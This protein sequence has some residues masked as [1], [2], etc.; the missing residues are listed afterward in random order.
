MR[1]STTDLFAPAAR[2]AAAG[3]CF[4][5][6]AGAAEIAVLHTGFHMRA[7]KVECGGQVC[8]LHSGAGRIEL[9]ASA[10]ARI[11]SEPDE[12]KPSVAQAEPLKKIEQPKAARTARE[13]VD[14]MARRNGLPPEIVHSVAQVESAYQT[15]AVSPKGA[16]GVM[17]LMPGTAKRLG[18]DP[19]DP[20]QNI[21]AGAQLLR[22][23]LL[24]YENDPNPVR[25]ALAAYNAGPGAVGKYGGVP[26]Y[27][28]TRQ[29]V[30]KVL[31]RYWKLVKARPPAD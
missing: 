2:A 28:E 3:L 17:Q 22:E 4:C 25:R 8:V 1:V 21:A 14:E 31:E 10:V 9:P 23:L 12:P 24:K 18:A 13:L 27:R 20:E 19:H 6:C 7:D 29:Y 11:E 15:R 16:I 5:L 26:P 30:E